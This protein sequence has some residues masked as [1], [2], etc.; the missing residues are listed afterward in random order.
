M[1]L[2]CI[3]VA[4]EVGGVG[5]A[6]AVP[7]AE[8]GGAEAEKGAAGP[9]AGVMAGVHAVFGEGGDFVADEADGLKGGD[10]GLEHLEAFFFG[11]KQGR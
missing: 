7:V 1:L 8:C 6:G 2:E 5:K 4:L 3:E 9:I 10:G 11:G